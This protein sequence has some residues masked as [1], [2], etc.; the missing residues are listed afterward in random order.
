MYY[1][2]FMN[3]KT[4]NY[5]YLQKQQDE[6]FEF[7]S[8]NSIFVTCWLRNENNLMKHDFEE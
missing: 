7:I 2:I 1:I 6:S 3:F 8:A 5:F 4:M